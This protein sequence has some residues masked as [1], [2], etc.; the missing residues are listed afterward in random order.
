MVGSGAGG[1]PLAA[2]LAIGGYSVLLLEAGDDQGALLQQQIPGAAFL[3]EE[4]EEMRWDYFVRHYANDTRQAQEYKT[5]YETPAG[6]RYVGLHPPPG[7]KPLG[8]LYPRAGTLGGCA[9]HNLLVTIY[10]HDSD[11]DNIANL[12]GDTSWAA[13][14]MR[15][16]FKRLERNGYLAAGSPGHG[17]DGWLGISTAATPLLFGDESYLAQGIAAAIAVGKV[18]ENTITNVGQLLGVLNPDINEDD[19]S[20]NTAADIWPSPLAIYDHRRSSP[21]H[22]VVET[23]HATYSYGTLSYHLDIRTNTLVTGVLFDE[24]GDKPKAIG[25]EFLEGQA[26]YR[27]DPRSNGSSTGTPGSVMASREV[28]LSAGAFN[29]PQLLKLS[30]IGPAEE[31][32]SHHIPVVADLPG[33][34]TN[35]QDR[36]EISVVGES[37][38]PTN[39]SSKCTAFQTLPDPCYDQWQ[40][41]EGFYTTNSGGLAITKRSSVAEAD[42]DLIL[43]NVGLWYTGYF[44]GFSVYKPNNNSLFTWTALKAHTRNTAGTVTLR[45][46]DPRDMPEINFHYFDEG[47]TTDGAADKDYQAVLEGFE[48]ARDIFQIGQNTTSDAVSPFTELW[49]GADVT[50]DEQLEHFIKSN[51][52]G[53][54]ASC[55]CP[56]GADVDPMAVLDS[57]FRVRGVDGLRVVDA[58]VF[59]KIPGFFIVTPIYIIAE[60]AADVIMQDA[61]AG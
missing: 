52:W 44:P 35:L 57:K 24:T 36:Y 55:T 46:S 19:P 16:Y 37:L 1:G 40:Q 56:I 43:F 48:L 25:V 53:H 12:T 28:I 14:S 39:I 15:N 2:R 4:V 3:V 18:A 9:A 5:V 20:R 6:D 59:P 29:T 49:P 30:G 22:F 47:T 60:K 26:L 42:N 45:S 61:R 38:T 54:H 17:F 23:A 50:S 27:A 10:P 51:S 11:W 31:L 32:N 21:R 58:S 8:I 33:V 34:G 7:S 41:G 13:S